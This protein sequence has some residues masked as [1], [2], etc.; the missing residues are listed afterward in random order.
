VF[1]LD[2]NWRVQM[3]HIGDGVL[4]LESAEPY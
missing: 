1:A 3:K 4:P 2:Q